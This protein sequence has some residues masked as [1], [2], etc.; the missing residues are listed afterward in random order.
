MS[1]NA[2]SPAVTAVA[3]T[4]APNR[5][6]TFRFS[7]D[8][9]EFFKIWI[10][11]LL[12]TVVTLGI[13]SA[14]ATVRTS[15]YFYGHT[16]LDETGF[17]YLANP[18]SI[19]IGRVIAVAIFGLVM[20]AASFQPM[21]YGVLM[22]LAIPAVPWLMVRAMR[23]NLR[24]TAYRNVR[25]DF[26]GTYGEAAKVFLLYY[27]GV[28]FSLGL[29]GPWWLLQTK[30]FFINN[31]RY[32]DH[33]FDCSCPT[34][35]FYILALITLGAMIP[36]LLVAMLLGW[37]PII[38]QIVI[39]LAYLSIFA[40]WQSWV[41][42]LLF[43]HTRLAGD[44]QLSSNVTM[45]D[46]AMLYAMNALLVVVTLGIALP[47][48]MVRTAKFYAERTAVQAA[49]LDRFTASQNQVAGSAIGD[50]VAGVFALEVGI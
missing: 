11:N 39:F 5:T 33:A 2:T 29:A 9:G 15:Q 21:L 37:I 35:E 3:K 50:E 16:K 23:F 34:K 4:E 10:V 31:A 41:R 47:W 48:V 27:L 6:F 38:G 17:Q 22:V 28:I 19:L 18:L 49:D 43:N 26:V 12:L 32:G 40:L 7:G 42:N 46:L 25:F 24:N 45:F 20:L 1:D 36:V 14:W 30:K 13:Y 44:V 8:G